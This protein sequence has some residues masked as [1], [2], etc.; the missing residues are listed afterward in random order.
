MLQIREQ[1]S[2]DIHE[3]DEFR[4]IYIINENNR[5]AYDDQTQC[6]SLQERKPKLN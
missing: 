6:A 3:G 1:E 2:S 4:S 5:I